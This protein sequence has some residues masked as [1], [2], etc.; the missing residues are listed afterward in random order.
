M[1]NYKNILKK[2]FFKMKKL[3]LNSF[4]FLSLFLGFIGIFIPVL[5]T[6]PFII[7]STFLFSKSNKKMYIYLK[8]NKHFKE[9]IENYETGKGVSK[10]TKIKA[11]IFLYISIGLSIFISRKKIVFFILTII[12]ILASFVI[13]SLK[14]EN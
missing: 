9:F 14:D 4:A 12:A 7:L 1:K 2:G 10:K 6:V 3:I 5:P 11:L 8:Q 13:I